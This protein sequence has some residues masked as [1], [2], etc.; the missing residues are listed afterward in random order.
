MYQSKDDNKFVVNNMT[1]NQNQTHP[2]DVVL[3]LLFEVVH[4]IVLVDGMTKFGD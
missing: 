3:F 1:F 4:I 2:Q